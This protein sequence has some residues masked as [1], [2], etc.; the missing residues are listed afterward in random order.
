MALRSEEPI[1]EDLFFLYREHLILA[2]KTV[3]ISVKT[4]FFLEITLILLKKPLF[5][6]KIEVYFG[7]HRTGIPTDLAGPGPTSG[8]RRPCV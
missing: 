3:K 1:G 7:V 2:V 4:S 8:S 6:M 5:S